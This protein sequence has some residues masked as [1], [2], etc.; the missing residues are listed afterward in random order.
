MKVEEDFKGYRKKQRVKMN[1]V[2]V[3]RRRFTV[4]TP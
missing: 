1:E 3:S 2:Q 4:G